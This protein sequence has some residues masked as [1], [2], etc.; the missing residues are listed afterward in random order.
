MAFSTRLASSHL[1]MTRALMLA[2]SGNC[3][4]GSGLRSGIRGLRSDSP[5]ET[6]FPSRVVW[7]PMTS[8]AG[9][10]TTLSAYASS[11]TFV[12][13]AGNG[14][15]RMAR[16]TSGM[17]RLPPKNE[18]HQAHMWLGLTFRSSGPINRFAIDVAA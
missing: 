13:L 2:S 7:I 11:M 5:I 17:L 14:A 12:R 3:S 16:L 4:L 15:K 8:R 1:S 6:L 18:H 9:I 10:W